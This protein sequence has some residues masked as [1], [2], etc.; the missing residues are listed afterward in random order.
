MKYENTK[1]KI[2]WYVLRIGLHNSKGLK[3]FFTMTPEEEDLFELSYCGT[4]I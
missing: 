3:S 1:G 4:I 2:R